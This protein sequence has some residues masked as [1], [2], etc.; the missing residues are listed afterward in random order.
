[1]HITKELQCSSITMLDTDSNLIDQIKAGYLADPRFATTPIGH[2]RNAQ[3]LYT[4]DG[5]IAIPAVP[6]IKKRLLEHF[7]DEL[8]HY[9]IVRLEAHIRQFYSWPGMTRAVSQF[10]RTCPTC[11]QTKHSNTQPSGLLSPMPVPSRPWEMVGMDFIVQLPHSNGY[12]AIITFTCLFS[13]QVHCVPTTTKVTA[14]QCAKLYLSHVY[15]LHGLSRVF[16]CDR[17]SKFTSDFWGAFTTLM[18]TKLNMSNAYP[19]QTDGQSER[20][21]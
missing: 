11:Q 4:F 19:A 10:C 6:A 12:D 16:T 7:H 20:T 3:G 5:K 9:G 1:M 13:K 21:N 14:K 17:D 18:G 2:K 8:G 15:K